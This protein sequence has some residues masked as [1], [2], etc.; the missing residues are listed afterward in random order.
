[1]VCKSRV[2]YLVRHIDSLFMSF[3]ISIR[4][5]IIAT[6]IMSSQ[7]I[8]YKMAEKIVSLSKMIHTHKLVLKASVNTYLGKPLNI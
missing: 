3:T 5:R 8:L 7:C 1:M 6:F 2:T 4:I